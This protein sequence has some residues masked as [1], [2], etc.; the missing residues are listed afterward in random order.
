MLETIGYM[1]KAI[2]GSIKGYI[3][4]LNVHFTPEICANYK[5]M[6]K[7]HAFFSLFM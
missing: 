2:S 4:A 5:E 6:A 3:M 7:N 1:F